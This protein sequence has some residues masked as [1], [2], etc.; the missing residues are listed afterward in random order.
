MLRIV[1]VAVHMRIPKLSIIPEGNRKT[2][3]K[4]IARPICSLDSV[5]ASQPEILAAPLVKGG[6]IK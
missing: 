3:K 2:A 1:F 6:E 5:L 4:I